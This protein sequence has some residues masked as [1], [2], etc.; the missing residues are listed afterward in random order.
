MSRPQSEYEVEKI[1]IEQLERQ[2]YSYIEM[3]N[4]DDVLA[5]FREQFCKVNKN[6]LLAAKGIA[7]LSDSEFDKL[8][9]RLDNHTIYESAKIL[10]EKWV[11]IGR[12]H[13]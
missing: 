10:R 5:N 4:Y 9:L 3:A 2:G 1:F 7:E 12:A 13:V 6:A 11:Q 8:L